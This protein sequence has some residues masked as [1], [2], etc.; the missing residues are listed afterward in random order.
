ML[1]RT[2]MAHLLGESTAKVLY[3]AIYELIEGKRIAVQH[4]SVLLKPL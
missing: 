2:A 3:E 1:M 4:H